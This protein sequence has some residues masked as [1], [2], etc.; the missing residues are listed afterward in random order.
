MHQQ[1]QKIETT[2]ISVIMTRNTTVDRMANSAVPMG[3]KKILNTKSKYLYSCKYHLQTQ[4]PCM[5]VT[6]IYRH[7]FSYAHANTKC[8]HT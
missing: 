8:A 1:M 5:T 4:V 7:W 3:K 2:I 6:A